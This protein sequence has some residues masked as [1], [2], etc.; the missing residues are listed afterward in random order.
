ECAIIMLADCVEAA[1]RSLGTSS[2]KLLRDLVKRIIRDK[3]ISGQ[4]DQSDLTLKDLDDIVEGFMPV[5]QG[6][7]HSRIEYPSI[8]NTK[9]KKE[10]PSV[11]EEKE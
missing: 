10:V 5:L 11:S 4:L 8:T 1:A 7:F 3:F 6:I 2:P 9:G